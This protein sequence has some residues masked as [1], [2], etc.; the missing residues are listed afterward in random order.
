MK[1]SNFGD[2]TSK[3]RN[4]SIPETDQTMLAFTN[5]PLALKKSENNGK[6][7]DCILSFAKFSRWVLLT[8]TKTVDKSQISKTKGMKG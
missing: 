2:V 6:G 4:M 1:S 5:Y 3:V 8:L 7:E